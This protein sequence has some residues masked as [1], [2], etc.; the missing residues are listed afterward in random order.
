MVKIIAIA[1]FL[2]HPLD[3]GRK[4]RRKQKGWAL[5]V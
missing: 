5:A 4:I 1:A 3:L 2:S